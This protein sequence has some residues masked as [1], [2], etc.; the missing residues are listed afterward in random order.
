MISLTT[1]NNFTKAPRQLLTGRFCFF[2]G[3]GCLLC[4]GAFGAA[5]AEDNQLGVALKTQPDLV[6]GGRALVG[7]ELINALKSGLTPLN[8]SA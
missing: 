2:S 6:L 4:G 5:L 7:L 3:L 8:T 1:Y